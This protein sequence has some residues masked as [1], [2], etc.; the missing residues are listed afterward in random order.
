MKKINAIGKQV[1]IIP[2]LHIPFEH[3]DAYKFLKAVKNKYINK[4]DLII[5]L[6][7]EVDGNQ[8]SMH[9]K[10]PNVMFS[11]ASEFQ[12]AIETIKKYYKLFPK[13][14][15][16]ESNHGSL[17]YRRASKFG[18]PMHV[19]KSYQDI[20]ETPNWNWHPDILL[21]TKMGEVYICHGKTSSYGKL[22]KEQGASAIQGHF[23]GKFEVTWHKTSTSERFNLFSGCL[24]DHEHLAFSYGKNHLPKPILGVTILSPNG[25]PRLIKMNLTNSGRWDGNLEL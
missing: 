7:D 15:L 16:C 22:C 13:M 19:M 14:E 3:K 25:Y 1:L 11:P 21:K 4:D 24:I 10:D 9:D 6:G 12:A 20:L 18:L 5:S 8:I 23:H 2:D 17:V